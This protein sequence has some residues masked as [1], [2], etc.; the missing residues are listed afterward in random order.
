MQRRDTPP[1][2]KLLNLHAVLLQCVAEEMIA[3]D[4][5]AFALS[6]TACRD[7]ATG[8]LHA[9]VLNEVAWRL[10]AGKQ[11]SDAICRKSPALVVPAGVTGI[12]GNAFDYCASLTSIVLLAGLTS[13]GRYFPG[14]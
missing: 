1:R 6:C 3:R 14:D 7:A 2:L 10:Q 9:V 4:F 13:V 12:G 5:A 8:A 11:V